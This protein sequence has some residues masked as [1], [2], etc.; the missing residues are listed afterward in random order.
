MDFLLLTAGKSENRID[1]MGRNR[2]VDIDKD[3]LE[4]GKAELYSIILSIKSPEELDS[5][6]DDML[7]NNE[8]QDLV[9]RY[10]LMDDLMKGK[11]QRD[12]ASDRSMSLCR[13]TRG[14]RM[15][16]K[17]NGFMSTWFSRKYDDYS[18]I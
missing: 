12:I 2:I 13:I 15:L 17:K 16:K 4:K 18:H 7:T 9:Q 1:S 6:F 3:E 10:L 8:I 14:S 11:S 5:F